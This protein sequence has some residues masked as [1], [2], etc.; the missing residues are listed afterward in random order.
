MDHK[1]IGIHG[2]AGVGK[3]TLAAL[4]APMLQAKTRS[5]ADPIKAICEEVFGFHQEYFSDRAVKEA[6]SNFW[7][8]S[9]RKAAQLIGTECF[10]ENFGDD[11]WIKYQTR[12]L[13]HIPKTTIIFT[14]VRF[15]NEADWIHREGGVIIHLTRQ[16][17]TGNV[18]IQN[19]ASETKLNLKGPTYEI[20]NNGSILELAVHAH[21]F[22]KFFQKEM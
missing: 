11:V 8:F 18:G 10:R 3:D 19:H 21:N 15:Q 20:E 16:D 9:P 14:D 7:G 12:G 5:F 17:Y 22:A 1:F 6:N 13:M 4:L 2:Y